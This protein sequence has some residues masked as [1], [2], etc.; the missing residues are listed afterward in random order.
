M[1]LSEE[2]L[3]KEK[4]LLS[5]FKKLLPEEKG[6]VLQRTQELLSDFYADEEL[7]AKYY[8]QIKEIPN[9]RKTYLVRYLAF[10]TA[11]YLHER[12]LKKLE[13]EKDTT[14][15]RLKDERAKMVAQSLLR[16]H[17][18]GRKPK[19]KE[20]LEKVKGEILSLRNQGLGIK[21]LA[22]YLWK[23][24]RLKVSPEYLRLVLAEWEGKNNGVEIKEGR[25]GRP[26]G[27]IDW[28]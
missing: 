18:R 7:V 5:L 24:H 11:V 13:Y 22:K 15:S 9:F 20:K 26:E 28:Y 1:K 3:K 23:A 6:L 19:K 14:Y 4:D 10:L 8:P 2:V 17:K 12:E 16:E 27:D 25:T 21:L